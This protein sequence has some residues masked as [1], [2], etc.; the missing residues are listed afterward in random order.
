MAESFCPTCGELVASDAEYCPNCGWRTN[1]SASGMIGCLVFALMMLMV[2]GTCAIQGIAGRAGVGGGIGQTGVVA[3]SALLVAIFAIGLNLSYR[4]Q[5]PRQRKLAVVR[6]T[7][8]LFV[9]VVSGLYAILRYLA[10]DTVQEGWLP[11][12][13]LGLAAFGLSITGIRT[14]RNRR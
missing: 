5:T 3:T 14:L 10:L 4:S 8:G 12:V 2:T 11:T 9:G 7:C 1:A 13:S 6:A